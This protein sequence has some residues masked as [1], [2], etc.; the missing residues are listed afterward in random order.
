MISKVASA[1]R[2]VRAFCRRTSVVCLIVSCGMGTVA[3]QPQ[4]PAPG[5][6]V[7]Q[8]KAEYA[9]YMAALS[10]TD[11]TKRA[12]SLA[13]FA[14]DYPKSVV[15]TDALEQEMAAWQ[16]AGDGSQV[17]RTA[18][19]LLKLDPGNVRV[20]GV[21]V[22]LDRQSAEEGDQSALNEMCADASGGMLAVPMWHRPNNMTETD[23]D[24]LSKLMSALFTGAEGYC[25]VAEKN[26]SQGKEWLIKAL[27][28]DPTN[29]RDTYQ[30]AIADLEGQPFD[31]D[32]IWYCAKAVRLEKNANPNQDSTGISKYCEQK[33][34]DY[35]GGDDGWDV[36]VATIATQDAPPK[37]FARQV[38]PAQK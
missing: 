15:L 4:A 21:V 3:Q 29:A 38:K 34:A 35:H 14:Q 22:A 8:S 11:P 19:Q 26:Y 10:P 5:Q 30:L 13:A 25:M 17:T 27:K 32:G 24:A 33:Y 28:I 36:L 31:V 12:E 1:S 20:L 18:K 16:I 9:A 2:G 7:I 23:F 37:D 6:K